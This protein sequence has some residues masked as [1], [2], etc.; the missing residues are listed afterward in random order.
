[1]QLWKPSKIGV[2][3]SGDLFDVEVKDEWRQA[4]LDSIRG[5]YWQTF[6]CLTKQPQNIRQKLY[7]SNQWIGVT[8]NTKDDLWRISY[9]TK[10]LK[11]YVYTKF[12]S[13]EPLLED[14]GELNLNGIDWIIIGAQTR[15][16]KQPEP[17]WVESLMLQARAYNI[18]IFFK[19]NLKDWIGKLQEFPRG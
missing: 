14:L 4:V 1:M 11:D 3:F 15:P 7:P 16:N 5:T 19:N 12:V 17:E 6:I 9:L 8:V 13:F 10:D 18:P 2:C